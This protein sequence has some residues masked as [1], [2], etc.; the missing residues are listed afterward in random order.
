MTLNICTHKKPPTLPSRPRFAKQR[1]DGAA[2]AKLARVLERNEKRTALEFVS[3]GDT[4]FWS[5]AALVARFDLS[6]CFV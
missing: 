1:T 6:F 5:S 4:S 2:I 3:N